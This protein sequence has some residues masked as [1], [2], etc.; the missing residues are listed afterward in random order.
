[1]RLMESRAPHTAER[2]E[3]TASPSPESVRIVSTPGTCGGKPRIDGHRIKVEHIAVCHKQMGMTLDEI[4]TTLPAITLA[5]VR[6]ALAY[7]HEHQEEIDAEIVEGK[8]F[9]EELRATSAP[10]KLQKLLAARK[11]NGM[12]DSLPPG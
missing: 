8:R 3:T 10:S 4:V 6:A 12:D 7:Y 9:V 1:M 5:H 11:A 2:T